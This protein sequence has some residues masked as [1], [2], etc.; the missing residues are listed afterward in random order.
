MSFT[1]NRKK[2]MASSYKPRFFSSPNTSGNRGLRALKFQPN[3]QTNSI[4][5]VT[6]VIEILMA[7]GCIKTWLVVSLH[8]KAKNKRSLVTK[9]KRYQNP[10]DFKK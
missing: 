9:A 5:L 8:S 6:H 2:K 1:P 7:S 10:K 3:Y 4:N